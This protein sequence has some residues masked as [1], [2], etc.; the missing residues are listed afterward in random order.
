MKSVQDK[1]ILSNGYGIPCV[2]FGTYKA[3][4]EEAAKCVRQAVR[5][6]YRHVDTA[7]FYHNEEGVGAGIR[8][9]G[10]PREELFLTSKVWNTQRGYDR[11][12]QSFEQSVKRLGVEYLDLYLIHWPANEKQFGRE[13]DAINADTWRA[14]ERLYQEGCVRAVGVSNF[15]KHHL[16]RLEKT[17]NLEPMV[18]QI[19]YHPG[20]GQEE[21]VLYCQQ[22]GITV[23][24]WSPL[25]RKAVLE[26]ETLAAIAETHGVTAAQV[27]LRWE[28]QH[29]IVPLPK[30]VNE[31]RMKENADIFGFE[32][33]R[34]QMHRI[35]SL[36]GIGGQCVNPDEVDF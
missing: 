31:S 5:C 10:L 19:E 26:D 27:C 4:G 22:N 36:Q 17:A 11:T 33:D 28:L 18:N 30:S 1:I 35:D 24:A 15:M 6:G 9:C 29:G 25:G 7:A 23:E 20:W 32:L 34:E 2:G 14:L 8:D 16:E 12:L 13:A 3:E 21:T